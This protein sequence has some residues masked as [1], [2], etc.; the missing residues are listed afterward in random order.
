MA[1]VTRLL[2]IALGLAV[3]LV[4][5]AAEVGAE[6]GLQVRP[7]QYESTIST[8]DLQ[9]GVVD[10]ANPSDEPVDV[11]VMVQGYRQ[12]DSGLEFYDDERLQAA[13]K[14]D[15]QSISLAGQD[16][17]RLVF[18]VDPQLLP[19][20]E[21]RAAIM[22][23]TISADEGTVAQRVSVGTLLQL[24]N[25]LAVNSEGGDTSSVVRW[26]VSGAVSA[27]LIAFGYM[28]GRNHRSRIKSAKR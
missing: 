4:V 17:Y 27:I 21:V 14:L 1:T 20:G 9:Q 25:Q 26:L 23:T 11:E 3:L 7:L 16:A 19:S 10:V 6:T 5:T 8:A 13:V 28:A 22:F 15:Q 24:N 2:L 18:E 12:S